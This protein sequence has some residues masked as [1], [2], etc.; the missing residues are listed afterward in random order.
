LL[1]EPGGVVD[2]GVVPFSAARALEAGVHK[3]SFSFLVQFKSKIK[4]NSKGIALRL[5][6]NARSG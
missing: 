5:A 4:S 3:G 2:Y 6:K 1:L